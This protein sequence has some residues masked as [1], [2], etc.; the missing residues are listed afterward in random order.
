MRDWGAQIGVGTLNL[1]PNR[2]EPKLL[3]LSVYFGFGFGFGS[4]GL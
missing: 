4:Y 2:I 3:E 1:K